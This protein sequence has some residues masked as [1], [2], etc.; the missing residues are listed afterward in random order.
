MIMISSPD[1][2]L[3]HVSISSLLLDRGA[4]VDQSLTDEANAGTT[5]L[6]AAAVQGTLARSPAVAP[7]PPPK[8]KQNTL[9]RL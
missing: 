9:T 2:G 8:Q 4:D 6:M 3:V 5:A 1:L 7:P